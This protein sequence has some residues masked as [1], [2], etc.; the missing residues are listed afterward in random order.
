MRGRGHPGA[1]PSPAHRGGAL[2]ASVAAAAGLLLGPLV[3]GFLASF[4]PWPT[5]S[6]FALDIVLASLLAL[7]LVR[8][9][10]TRPTKRDESPRTPIIHV[11]ADI[12]TTFFATALAGAS[13]F[14]V[15]GWIFGLSPSYLHEEL[16][17]H[18]TQPVVAGLFA[19]LAA[20]TNGAIQLVLRRHHSATAMRTALIGVVTGMALMAASTLV[21][22]LPLAIV[23]AV[24]SGAG[25]GI[26]QMNAMATIQR[27]APIHA[28]GGVTSAYFTI[29]YL[30]MSVPV[31]IAGEAA[32]RFGL[33]IVT[34]WFLVGVITLV[35]A[36]LVLAP[37]LVE[38]PAEDRVANRRELRVEP[39]LTEL[40]LDRTA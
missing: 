15:V 23:G 8:I 3:S 33:G 31:I 12:R 13:G 11:P 24:V 7:A 9:P 37:R 17:V 40:A 6:P 26:S 2:A 32:D 16:H 1:P 4:T 21:N 35:G 5:V 10:E 29:C 27:I 36:A 14:M 19:A 30:A 34:G 28:R 20:A 38:T 25:A 18:I 22:S 39:D